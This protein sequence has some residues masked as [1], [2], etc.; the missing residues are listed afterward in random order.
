M[1]EQ[2]NALAYYG[3]STL[4]MGN[5]IIVEAPGAYITKLFTAMIYYVEQKAGAIAIVRHFLQALINALAFYVTKLITA[6]I[7]FMIQAPGVAKY[8]CQINSFLD[9]RL[10]GRERERRLRSDAKK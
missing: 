4:L 6:V 10:R 5:I 2:T 3:V 9:E 8:G 7:S 1:L